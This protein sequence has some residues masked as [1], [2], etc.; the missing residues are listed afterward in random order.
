MTRSCMAGPRCFGRAC[1]CSRS[2]WSARVLLRICRQP[3]S[4]PVV[5]E[6]SDELGRV[7]F[8]VAA[9]LLAVS[10]PVQ[11]ILAVVEVFASLAS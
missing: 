9:A 11:I 1:W 3:G 7:G 5:S 2:G 10:L 8:A 6:L 4:Y